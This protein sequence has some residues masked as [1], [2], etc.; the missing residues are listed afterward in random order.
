MSE[1]LYIPYIMV[2]MVSMVADTYDKISGHLHVQQC[3]WKNQWFEIAESTLHVFEKDEVTTIAA[4]HI[5]V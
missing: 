3:E 5:L 4:V 1:H 2:S